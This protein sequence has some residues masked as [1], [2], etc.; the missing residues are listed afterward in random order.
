MTRISLRL[1]HEQAEIAPIMTEIADRIVT[2]KCP[3]CGVEVPKSALND[4]T[5][6]LD[7]N[8]PLKTR[9]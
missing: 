5:R 3:S 9:E 1:A 7:S 6:C 4:P 2:I 8:C